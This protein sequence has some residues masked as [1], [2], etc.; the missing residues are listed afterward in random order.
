MTAPTAE[1]WKE[2]EDLAD[3][4]IY[5][6]AE[7]GDSGDL[8][9]IV[10]LRQGFQ[11]LVKDAPLTSV[12]GLQKIEDELFQIS[13]S[14]LSRSYR[15]SNSSL[16]SYVNAMPSSRRL[17]E[18]LQNGKSSKLDGDLGMILDAA[19][20]Y[21]PGFKGL[22]TG[23]RVGERAGE[24]IDFTVHRPDRTFKEITGAK[25]LS[26]AD[27]LLL[28]SQPVKEMITEMM[29]I[30]AKSPEARSLINTNT[31]PT[32][33]VYTLNSTKADREKQFP[34]YN[35]GARTS[36]NSSDLALHDVRIRNIE[37]RINNSAHSAAGGNGDRPR[38]T[39]EANGLSDEKIRAA[40]EQLVKSNVN[41][42]ETFGGIDIRSLSPDE[43]KQKLEQA[44]EKAKNSAEQLDLLNSS[45]SLAKLIFKGDR[46]AGGVLEMIRFGIVIEKMRVD[47]TLSDVQKLTT[48]IGGLETLLAFFL[49]GGD[50]TADIL[51][52]LEKYQKE[53]RGRFN[54]L[55][56]EISQI[57]H[58]VSNLRHKMNANFQRL[59]NYFRFSHEQSKTVQR[60]MMAR[61]N[62]ILNGHMSSEL[63]GRRTN[64]ER[65]EK[66]R[67]DALLNISPSARA[68]EENKTQLQ[69]LIRKQQSPDDLEEFE[70]CG[71]YRSKVDNALNC[72]R[73]DPREG[74]YVGAPVSV[75]PE[76]ARTVENLNVLLSR[77]LFP[78][79]KPKGGNPERNNPYWHLETIDSAFRDMNAL[80]PNLAPKSG[81]GFSSNGMHP[82]SDSLISLS[83][84]ANLRTF[85]TNGDLVLSYCFTGKNK[86][87]QVCDAL[88]EKYARG[89]QDIHRLRDAIL[90][91][92]RQY[93]HLQGIVPLDKNGLPDSS[94]LWG[95]FQNY[96]NALI[97]LHEL[98]G[99]LRQD[100]F[101]KS[102]PGILKH[103]NPDAAVETWQVPEKVKGDRAAALPNV[104]VAPCKN[105][106]EFDASGNSL[107]LPSIRGCTRMARH[108]RASIAAAT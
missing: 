29:L 13:Q 106:Q 44:L 51:Q 22:K 41:F 100:V 43:I 20:L 34:N 24:A 81:L 26:N 85:A 101:S 33:G 107:L 68:F 72:I 53:M 4:F 95:L 63:T 82:E 57:G 37:K 64:I 14:K 97:A 59:I 46:A 102:V 36:K 58:E 40:V 27:L 90:P 54:H 5:Q 87:E 47:H 12:Q 10:T 1:E 92:L 32:K 83:N 74:V 86:D 80:H 39:A 61:M 8:M 62:D 93:K 76:G 105:Y 2:A 42:S 30:G 94:D 91:N 28:R 15:H 48:V 16:S 11:G 7:R 108:F 77:H 60:V 66:N 31:E 71:N 18:G 55:D 52:A 84:F 75:G 98:P 65:S 99:T 67:E 78:P 103:F 35:L 45:V 17:I 3:Y 9:A 21:N 69:A 73:L 49:S 6:A 56:N 89:T 104:E 38:P 50:G 19:A 25:S 70:R 79:V 96:E 88:V 23:L